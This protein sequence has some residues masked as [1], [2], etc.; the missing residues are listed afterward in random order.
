MFGAVEI[1]WTGTSVNAFLWL[2]PHML[3]NN[4]TFL[5][6]IATVVTSVG[7]L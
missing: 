3:Y 2:V 4:Y 6:C 5:Q 1:I 7:V